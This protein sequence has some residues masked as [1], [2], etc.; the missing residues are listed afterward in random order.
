VLDDR[1]E[2]DIAKRLSLEIKMVDDTVECGGHQIQ[3][4][5]MP[6]DRMRP[7]KR[8]PGTPDY[9]DANSSAI[10]QHTF[11]RTDSLTQVCDRNFT[12]I[13]CSIRPL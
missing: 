5:A 13:A 8:N 7:A 2:C 12:P 11:L 3:V 6:V 1:T 4:G 10:M 9:G